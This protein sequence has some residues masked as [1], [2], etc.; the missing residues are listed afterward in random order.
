MAL[1]WIQLSLLLLGFVLPSFASFE[2]TAIV[3]SVDVGGSLVHIT[4]T[5]AIKALEDGSN[6]YIFALSEDEQEKTSWIKAKVKGQSSALSLENHGL[7]KD[8]TYYYTVVLPETLGVDQTVN[9]VLETVQTHATVPLPEEATQEDSQR[10]NYTTGLFVLSPYHT[11][12]QRTKIRTTSSGIISYTHPENIDQFVT[13]SVAT[14]AASGTTITYGPF[15]DIPKSSNLDFINEHQQS[16]FI[17]Y[18]YGYPVL[19]VKKLT[20]EAEISHWGANL[21][22]QD[23][24]HLYNAGPKLKGHF[25]RLLHQTQEYSGRSPAHVIKQLTLQLPP[26]IHSTYYYDLVGNVSTSH[27]RVA[28]SPGKAAIATQQSLLELQPRYPIMGGWNYSFTLGWNSPLADSARWDAKTERYIVG[29]PIMTLIAGAVV[30]D[31]DIKVILPEAATDIKVFPPFPS[32]TDSLSTHTTYL[33]T[34]GRPVISLHYERL[35]DKHM[36]TIYVS[37]KVPVSAHLKKPIAVATAFLGLF[38]VA[39]AWKRV[40]LRLQK[41]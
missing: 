39:F 8:S 32:V 1:R 2:N 5:F 11:V 15:N 12:V 27:L 3:R 40:D 34:T 4:T 23:N 6:V 22:I 10:L 16:V 19:T 9:L 13:D 29:V 30:D 14:L 31:A 24:I 18:D 38:A 21:N 35:T 37:Y 36:G 41:K 25:S 28:P 26:G 33:D 20:R 7:S 17:H